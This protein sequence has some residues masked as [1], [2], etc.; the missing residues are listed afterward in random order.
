[1]TGKGALTVNGVMCLVLYTMNGFAKIELNKPESVAA[2]FC[3][4]IEGTSRKHAAGKFC[5]YSTRA[6]KLQAFF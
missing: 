5:V 6:K 3:I 2:Q 4:A 1:M